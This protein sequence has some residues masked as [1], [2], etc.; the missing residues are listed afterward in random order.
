LITFAILGKRQRKRSANRA[1]QLVLACA[2]FDSTGRLMVTPEG[3]IPN[4]KITNTYVEKVSTLKT[5]SGSVHRNLFLTAFQTFAEDEFSKTHPAFIWVFRASR[6]WK[7][8]RDL[9][10]G[11]K[12]NLV[13]NASSRRYCPGNGTVIDG[14]VQLD[15]EFST[16]FKQL[17]CVAAQ[18]L[19]DHMHQPLDKIGILYDDVMS[20]GT[21]PADTTT[22]KLHRKLAAAARA[23]DLEK[24][25]IPYIFG[26]GQ[27]LFVV[28]EVQ[29]Q[30]VIRLQASGFRFA[31]IPAIADVLSRSMQ[32]SREEMMFRLQAMREYSTTEKLMDPGVHI[33][34]FALRPTVRKGFDVLV[35]SQAT[36]Q[37]PHITMP[38]D[39]ISD[40]QYAI[41]RK[42][43]DWTMAECL[44][45][46]DG[47]TGHTLP[48]EQNFCKQMY[49]A[50]S[51]LAEDID[52][53]FVME[54]RF[55]AKMVT[56]PC[57]PSGRG[58]TPGKAILLCVRAITGIH[59][60]A[61]SARFAYRPL[62]LF[63]AQQQV[64]TGVDDHEWFARQIHREFADIPIRK[65][66]KVESVRGESIIGSPPISPN[67]ATWPIPSLTPSPAPTRDSR[68][69]ST[70][71]PL[72][73]S[74]AFGGIMVSNQSTIDVSELNKSTSES[75]FE[76]Q[77]MG[78]V[79]QASFEAVEV[80]TFVDQLYAMAVSDGRARIRKMS[81]EGR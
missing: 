77:G 42:M 53:P 60:L 61:P 29:K 5:E 68:A 1:Q 11:M 44:T 13:S 45:W 72:M 38:L 50:L 19:A 23:N 80:E 55:A 6:N 62:R 75:S 40:W 12:D 25:E 21:L 27:F 31:G 58:S 15:T 16:L 56:A 49:R 66:R 2:F 33:A 69:E 63:N 9:I 24:A 57:R 7:A 37:L 30:E 41:L 52:S 17:F 81:T 54:T 36:N 4:Q 71:K 70:D 28:R 32:V 39:H 46:L 47:D 64:Y 76:L 67:T 78:N 26:K 73:S 20:T 14:S 8:L 18:D 34:C 74:Q 48:Y 3:M 65:D 10:P 51:R 79:G 22:A 59:A 43:D 35:Q